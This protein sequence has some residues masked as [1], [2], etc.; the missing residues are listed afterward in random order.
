MNN[1]NKLY[2][3][4]F[5]SQGAFVDDTYL[6][7]KD[8]HFEPQ[9]VIDF[10]KQ[11]DSDEFTIEDLTTHPRIGQY[12]RAYSDEEGIYT[13]LYNA[14]IG[15]AFLLYREANP[16]EIETYKEETR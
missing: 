10:L 6:A 15:G 14:S 16:Y 13:L 8:G 11:W 5:F 4:V 12:D 7:D 1:K 9:E 2:R 3:E